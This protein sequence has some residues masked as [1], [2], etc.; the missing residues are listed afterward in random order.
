MVNDLKLQQ[1]LTQVGVAWRPLPREQ[2]I[3]LSNEWEGLY[4]HCFGHGIR[5]REGARAQF[6]YSQQCT[7]TFM[8]VPFLGKYGG[9]HS[10]N[11]RG[12]RKAAYECHGDG[13]LPDMSA[14]AETDFFIVPSDL[15]WTMIHTHEDYALG[16]PYFLRKDWLAHPNERRTRRKDGRLRA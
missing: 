3:L 14:F 2:H 10:I 12:A 11:K 13:T 7:Q 5:Y 9:P 15:S 4:G 16:G 8:I 1:F 6:E